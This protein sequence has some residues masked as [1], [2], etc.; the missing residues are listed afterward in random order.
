M[1]R[2]NITIVT[3]C[4]NSEDTIK[5]TLESVLKQ[6]YLPCE[7][8]IVD[9]KSTDRT[10]SILEEYII[11]FEAKGIKFKIVS[12]SDNG[13]YDAMNKGVR[14]ASGDVVGILN[15]DDWYDF[16]A[17]KIINDNYENN[18]LQIYY[19]SIRIWKK[20]KEY[21][22]RQHH[23]NYLEENVIQHPTCFVPKY[24][25]DKYGVYDEKLKIV[26]DYEFL[27]RLKILGVQFKSIDKIITNFRF[28]GASDKWMLKGALEKNY[29][30]YKFNFITYKRYN[31]EKAK[32]QLAYY[33][34]KIFL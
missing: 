1:D 10:L 9:G 18:K 34:K 20:G 16:N 19:G 28:G 26:A 6:S 14:L 22:T 24:I 2:I 3:V 33:L 17:L 31:F 25:Y 5:D 27:N 23:H 15:S 8:I 29:V 12:E 30:K 21:M 7:Y 13:I 32:I 11:Q 4:Y